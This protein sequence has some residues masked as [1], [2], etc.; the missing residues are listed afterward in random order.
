MKYQARKKNK[1]TNKQTNKK[2]KKKQ[3]Q[4]TLLVSEALLVMVGVSSPLL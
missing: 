4:K 1:K 3:K 2:Q